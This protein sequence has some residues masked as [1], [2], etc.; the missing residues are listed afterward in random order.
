MA[1]TIPSLYTDRV[2][3]RLPPGPRYLLSK[4]TLPILAFLIYATNAL[5]NSLSNSIYQ[6]HHALPTG[7]PASASLWIKFPLFCILT[8]TL[9]A[10]H[11]YT[12]FWREA[13]RA[14]AVGAEVVP[15]VGEAWPSVLGVGVMKEVMR[16]FRDGYPAGF[17]F[18]KPGTES[19]F[20][21]GRG[22]FS[23]EEVAN[24]FC[25]AEVFL[26]WMKE[27]GNTF[28]LRAPTDSRII[29]FEPDHIKVSLQ[30]STPSLSLENFKLHSAVN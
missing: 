2:L 7:S 8:S 16:S 21:I 18:S 22:V 13:R 25:V 11:R 9:I 20:E 1:I 28:Q 4:P 26:D 30:A 3:S 6:S 15:A 14:R 17:H 29:T 27:Y 24:G 19:R 23:V 5:S 12:R 10:V